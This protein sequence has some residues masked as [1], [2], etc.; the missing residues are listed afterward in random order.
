MGFVLALVFSFILL[1]F[2]PALAK[3]EYTVKKGDTLLAIAKKHKVSV[4]EIQRKNKVRAKSLKPGDTLLIP[5]KEKKTAAAKKGKDTTALQETPEKKEQAKQKRENVDSADRRSLPDTTTYHSVKKGDTLSSIGRQYSLTA[6]K[7]KDMNDL[8]SSRLRIGQRLIVGFTGTRTYVIKKGDSMWRIAQRFDLDPDE[9]MEM[10]NMETPDLAIGRKIVLEKRPEPVVDEK[11]EQ[12]AKAVEAEVM[13]TAESPDVADQDM[14]SRLM[15][16]AKKLV[17]IPYKFGGNSFLGI[18][19][20]AYVRKVYGYL[21]IDLPRTAREQFKT[22]ESVEKHELDVGD[23]VFFQTY[24]PFPSHVGIYIGNNLFI[25]ASSRGKKVTI[26]SLDT[27]Y[28][29]KRFI[30]AKRLITAPV[31]GIEPEF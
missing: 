30:G 3:T 6:A 27:P 21:G 9:L 31:S 26:D 1:G 17:N 23:L 20:S 8:R 29:V 4:K 15:T 16:F 22:G 10:N 13:K 19:C 12:I 24:A 14:T 28:Y 7:L 18:D 2:S 25:H 11:K 5:T